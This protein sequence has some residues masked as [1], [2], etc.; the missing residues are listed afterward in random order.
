V[1]DV[2]TN[3]NPARW[4]RICA[5]FDAAQ[6][7]APGERPA[8]L[9]R[10][11]GSDGDLRRQV[12]LLL[13]AEEAE[14]RLESADMSIAKG[15][16]I[17]PYRLQEEVGRGGMGTVWRAERADGEFQQTVAVKLIKRGMDTNEVIRRFAQERQILSRLDHPNIARLLDG[18]ST[19][20]GRPYLVMEFIEGRP[21]VEYCEAKLLG[22]RARLEIFR[23]ICGAVQHAHNH[24]V[25]H[26][27]LKPRNVMV[28]A[29]GVVKLLDFGI[30]KV[31]DTSDHE[32]LTRLRP[33]TPA[34]ASPEQHSGRALTTA[35]DVYSLGLTLD[36]LVPGERAAD[37]QA[38]VDKATREEPEQRYAT[39]EQLSEDVLRYLRGQPVEAR[40]GALAYKAAKLLSRYA[41]PA[42]ASVVLL[43]AALGVLAYVAIQ[44]RN[45]EVER[46]R[47]EQVSLF[48]RELFSAADPERN[49]GNRVSTRELLDL[50]AARVRTLANDDTRHALLD[51]MAEAY[52]NLGLYEKAIAA[53]KELLDSE[54]AGTAP[55]QTRLARA[56]A[57]VAEAE[58]FRGRHKEGEAAGLAAVQLAKGIGARDR[59]MVMMHRCNQLRQAARAADA[60][61]ACREAESAALTAGAPAT[62]RSMI[63]GSLGTALMDASKFKEAEAAYQNALQLAQSPS[64]RAQGLSNLGSL[65][66][67]QG[68]FPDAEKTF[69]EA[70][71]LKR[72]LY[73]DG[74]LDLAQ[75]L[76]NLANVL[77]TVHREPDAVSIYLEAHTLYRKFLGPESSE[78]ASSLSN[79]AIAYAVSGRLEEAERIAAEVVGIQSRTIGP[80]TPPHISSLIKH[81]SILL[82][83]GKRKESVDILESA[84]ALAEKANP[85]PK[86]QAGYARVL[87][88]EGMLEQGNRARAESLAREASDILRPILKPGHWMLQQNSIVLAGALVRGGNS[89]EGQKLLEPIMAETDSRRLSGWWAEL[90]RR[91]AKEARR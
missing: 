40:T 31:L 36:A 86:L 8:L 87:L 68:R 83:R 21:L 50:G 35:T 27:D 30:A 80:G 66:F 79:L 89:P 16:A 14:R 17:G 84:V 24:L 15:A 29:D 56:M 33:L 53:Y 46:D 47:A 54:Q 18:G 9:D 41:V 63:A 77:V 52:F 42:L 62:E 44:K 3:P 64:A 1:N 58:E 26:R 23:T 12:E 61:T 75:S 81:G 91:Y 10:E 4:P 67:R 38:I 45:V 90:A 51:T 20:E 22:E 48:L 49:Q 65:Y 7:L 25:I 88:A 69:R 74:H 73:P 37:L 60:V 34:F 2:E 5:I 11:C 57:R 55:N 76:N 6:A 70:I 59:A 32:T 85:K 78:L 72:K 13:E 43:A 39:A 82:E 28:R 71:V 19:E